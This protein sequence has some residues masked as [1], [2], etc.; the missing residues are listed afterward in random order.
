[1]KPLR[2]LFV[3]CMLALSAVAGAGQTCEE[4]ELAPGNLKRAFDLALTT[5]EALDASGAR[6][7][8]LARAGQDLSRW[9]LA[10][11]H[12]GLAWRDHPAGRWIVVHLLNDCGAASS[13][14]Y[15]E[16]LANFFSDTPIRWEALAIIPPSD[17]QDRIAA[18]LS[19]DIAPRMHES[20]Y[21]MAAYPFSTRYQNSNQWLLEVVAEALAGRTMTDRAAA[22]SWLREGGYRPTTLSM[23]ASTRL[24][25]RMF[26]ANVAF[27]DHPPEQRWAGRID[28]VSVESIAAFLA[29]HGATQLRLPPT[30]QRQARMASPST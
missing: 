10:W 12:A 26:R 25:A 16:G 17:V 14:L 20:A 23:S 27:D 29:R 4:R 9:G 8:I 30:P 18:G 5:R 22:Q 13:A 1:M 28:T 6:V 7:V 19:G 11:S 15:N 21:N 2:A 24:G 3:L